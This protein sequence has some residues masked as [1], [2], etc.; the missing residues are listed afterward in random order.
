LPLDRQSKRFLDMLAASGQAEGGYTSVEQRRRALKDLSEGAGGDPPAVA[1]VHEA[2]LPGPG[3][4][5]LVRVYT[6]IGAPPGLLS[7]MVFFH[8]GGWVAGDLDTHDG[9][10]RRLA[11]AS[12]C[13]IISVDYRLA[14]EHPF[15]AAIEDVGAAVAAIFGDAEAFGIDARRLGVAGDSAGGGLAAAV[16]QMARQDGPRIAFQ[17]L[18]CP[19]LDVSTES[20][21]RMELAEGYFLNRATLERDLE[22]YGPKD[23]ADP[24]VSP[25][26]AADLGGLPPA[27]IHTAEFDPFR[28]EGHAYAQRLRDAGNAVLETCHPG[29]IHYFYAMPRIIGHAEVALAMMGGEIAQLEPHPS[30]GDHAE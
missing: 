5:I 21:S 22:L 2:E 6:P 11:N 8:G 18:I 27:F 7:G 10:C 17:L 14:P 15:P 3:G 4:S 23:R 9:V 1:A 24:R 13:R 30:G 19:I 12:V 26:R 29:M 25:L 16:C 28:D 20:A